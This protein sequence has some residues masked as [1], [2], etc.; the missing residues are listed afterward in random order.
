[1]P[2]KQPP[3]ADQEKAEEARH[4]AE[5][6]IEAAQQGQSEEAR[7]L[8]GEAKSLDKQAAEEVLT[9]ADLGKKGSKP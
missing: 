6:A 4:V 5:D 7:F 9:R 2:A 1:M 8:A 3:P